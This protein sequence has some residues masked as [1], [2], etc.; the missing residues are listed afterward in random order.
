MIHF[1]FYLGEKTEKFSSKLFYIQHGSEYGTS[2]F[3][4]SENLETNLSDKFF[5]WGW[6]NSE[7]IQPIGI[8]KSLK[9]YKKPSLLKKLL[10][11]TRLQKFKFNFHH[12]HFYDESWISYIA[13]NIKFIK[14]L[15]KNNYNEEIVLR[16][17]KL[18]ILI[19]IKSLI[20]N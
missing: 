10:F 14:A 8:I 3:F 1:H 15:R 16:L 13:S 9:M 18:E 12:G 17:K 4:F 6:K 11:I 2:K 19:L 20:I 5:S 7:K